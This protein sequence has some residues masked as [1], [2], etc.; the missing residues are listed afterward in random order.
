MTRS[1]VPSPSR[2]CGSRQSP[3]AFQ[4]A[5]SARAARHCPPPLPAPPASSRCR[6]PSRREVRPAGSAA[7]A[8][9]PVPQ[10]RIA[11]VR[12]ARFERRRHGRLAV[13][14]RDQHVAGDAKRAAVEFL[15]PEDLGDRLVRQPPH[16]QR[17]ES[18][19]A[20]DRPCAA[21]AAPS[22]RRRALRPSAIRHRAARCPR[23]PRAAAPPRAALRQ[24]WSRV[25]RARAA[26]PRP[27]RSARR[28]VRPGPA[29]RALR[30]SLC[31]V[32]PMR[33]SVTRPCGKL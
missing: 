22:A 5:Q 16:D 33:W 32:R 30:A 1:N 17:F 24:P 25:H 19:A 2:Q 9:E 31:R 26:W 20:P 28:S 21:A 29:R 13:G 8:P 3:G 6:S 27:R 15:A 23:P 4:R 12:R 11:R 14:A 10:S 7:S 18:V